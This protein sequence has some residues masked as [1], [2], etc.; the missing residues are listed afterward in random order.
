MAAKRKASPTKAKAPKAQRPSAAAQTAKRC[1]DIL[2][3]LNFDPIMTRCPNATAA[4]LREYKRFLVLKVVLKD[5]D[6]SVL[7]PPAEVD[8]L[9]HAHILDTKHY[10]ATCDALGGDF[11]DHNPDGG[12]DAAARL[13]RRSTALAQYQQLFGAS[14]DIWT[15]AVQPVLAPIQ[16]QPAQQPAQPRVQ[17]PAQPRGPPRT[18]PLQDDEYGGEDEGEDDEDDEELLAVGTY[19][20]A[21]YQASEHGAAG[22]HW[23]KGWVVLA[24]WPTSW[25]WGEHRPRPKYH[26]VYEDG[27]IEKFVD[28]KFVK[29]VAAAVPMTP[30]AK[31]AWE[32]AKDQPINIKVM[33]QDGY[34]VSFK[35]KEGTEFRKLM[36][37]FCQRQGISENTVRFLLEGVKLDH[38]QTPMDVGM[39]DGDIIDLMVEQQ[40]C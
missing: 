23:Y 33:T 26:I 34:E 14:P 29:S 22:T 25:A 17:Q 15:A 16:Q 38:A 9:W 11:I 10:R 8:T 18:P 28:E 7:S 13:A 2:N 36:D 12:L 32:I 39:E 4:L 31:R 5:F 37:A 6:A 40:G 20:K 3:A 21:R 19:V 27:D 35:M 1:I 30:E 24:L